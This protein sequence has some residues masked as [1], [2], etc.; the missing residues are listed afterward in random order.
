MY[1]K[2][3]SSKKNSKIQGLKKERTKSKDLSSDGSVCWHP[4][5]SSQDYWQRLQEDMEKIMEE[6][7]RQRNAP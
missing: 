7:L 5:L 6:K 3:G 2:F 4:F 1:L